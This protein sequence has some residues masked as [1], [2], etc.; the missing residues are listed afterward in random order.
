MAITVT[1]RDLL[2]INSCDAL[3]ASR[4]NFGTGVNSPTVADTAI[5]AQ[6]TASWR[7]RVT[8]ANLGGVGDDFGSNQNL[9]T[10]SDGGERHIM[11]WARS[12][13]GV[14][15]A[16]QGWRI[17]WGTGASSGSPY[18]EINV[19]DA[20]T[21][22]NVFNGF[23]NFCADPLSR[24]NQFAGVN[25]YPTAGR[26]FGFA[27]DHVTSSSRDT[28]FIDEI[29]L[30]CGILVTG[31][32]AAPR[33]APEIAA[34]DAT[35]GRGMFVDINGIY[36]I[37][38]QVRIGDI[39]AATN[40]IF[41]D[42][43]KIWAFQAG[44]ISSTFHHLHFVGG[45]GTN[46]ATFGTKVG[47]GTTAVGVSGNA[48]L[49]TGDVPFSVH[50]MDANIDVQ[51]Y[52]CTF[53]CPLARKVDKLARHMQD[54]GGVFAENSV[55][56]AQATPSQ[57]IFIPTPAT[58]NDAVYD[59]HWNHFSEITVNVNGANNGT[60]TV[61]GEYYNGTAWV[62]LPNINYGTLNHFRSVATSTVTWTIPQ[63]W[64]EIAVNSSTPL[65]YIRFRVDAVT[66]GGTVQAFGTTVTT[67]MGG[68]IHI[69]QANAE[70]ISCSFSN[71]EMLKI[72]NGALFQKCAIIASNASILDAAI[73]LGPD[74]PAAD[75]FREIAIQNCPNGILL[76]DHERPLNAAAAVDK[77]GGLVGI[78]ITAHGWTTGKSV[79]L[80]GTT[81]YNATYT[82]DATTSVNEIVV[83]ATFI[84]ETFAI[85]DLANPNETYNFRKITFAGNTN[86]VRVDFPAASTVDINILESGDTPSIQ[87]VDA[88]TTVNVNNAVTVVI[89]GIAE[90]TAVRVVANETVGTVTA[91]DLIIEAL[92]SSAGLVSTV[93]NYEAAFNPS[94]LD[95]AINAR[96]Q[97]LPNAAIQDDNGVFADETTAANS[98][99]V[100]DMN[101]LPVTPVVNQDRYIFGHSEQFNRLKVN[102][103]TAGTGGF[104]ITWQYWNGAWVNL[105][106]VVDGTSSFS[107]LGE[108]IIS[109]TLPGDWATSTINSQ[110][111]F[112]YIRAAYTAGTVTIT[113]LGRASTLDVTRYLPIP[114]TGLL[115]RTISSTGLTATLSQAVD[116]IAK[117]DPLND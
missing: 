107:V 51:F 117:F 9:E 84:A 111:P 52:G 72:R 100:G 113:P 50:A 60:Y 19:G 38:G 75:T 27:A 99:A 30:Q 15:A 93:I 76:I 83:A 47:T 62:T 55:R 74:D 95:I 45:T 8:A 5:K 2:Q 71:F 25:V 79:T 37:L 102:V 40:S 98:A 46:R 91:G 41:E 77:G 53:L 78:P 24:D 116:S 33:G 104:T 109:F 57:T 106:G 64:E 4:Y 13:D 42:S 16:G 54:N 96:N 59:G 108:N 18:Q 65:Y 21:S 68:H 6:G 92:A 80:T 48:F 97:G 114:P 44:S 14:S 20:N 89:N 86:D 115:V 7:A 110:G 82:L 22:R 34:N 17:R 23:F 85:T 63:D 58:V 36:Y 29:K 67:L 94:G 87:K 73:D 88:A 28:F 31:G 56:A 10:G 3:D 12:L 112:F 35:N 43:N 32:A 103:S 1:N 105:S 66:A 81:N 26:Y 69:E 49:S 70:F 101:L 61:V 11:I 39:T 90:G